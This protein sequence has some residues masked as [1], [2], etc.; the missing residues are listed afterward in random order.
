MKCPKAPTFV[1]FACIA[2]I[3]QGA[4]S[5]LRSTAQAYYTKRDALT[6]RY[7]LQG[8]MK[9]LDE[10]QTP[11]FV[12]TSLPGPDGKRTTSTRAEVI[13]HTRAKITGLVKLRDLPKEPLNDVL[14]IDRVV[15]RQTTAILFLTSSASITMKEPDMPTHTIRVVGKYEDTWIKLNG[16]WKLQAS[17]EASR[18]SSMDGKVI[19]KK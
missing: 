10:F 12:F 5:D 15:A 13:Q 9:L 6:K 17:K 14:H 18:V 3:A 2:A 16:A 4:S 19:P 11:D 1:S 8:L 7:D